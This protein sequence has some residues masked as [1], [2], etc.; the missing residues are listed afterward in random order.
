MSVYVKV[1]GGT[2]AGCRRPLAE[3]RKAKWRCDGGHENPPYA[4][5]CLT[6]GCHD[7]RP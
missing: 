4:T 1:A 7:R 6:R 2:N 5:R 3:P